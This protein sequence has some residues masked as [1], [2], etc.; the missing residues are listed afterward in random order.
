MLEFT[1]CYLG[2]Y[3]AR[4]RLY[5]VFFILM[6]LM[7]SGCIHHK[8]N[9][10][11]SE[12]PYDSSKSSARKNAQLV[13][14]YL[15]QGYTDFAQEKLQI[16][17]QQAPY[18]P[19]VLDTAGYFYEKTGRIKVANRYYKQAV[20]SAPLSGFAKNNY[21]SFLCRNGYYEASIHYFLEA[22]AMPHTP[23]TR[24]ALDNAKYCKLQIKTKLG[25]HAT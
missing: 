8:Q 21:G 7:L 6:A 11:T 12:Q 20:S 16:A 2:S 19:V 5:R 25:D 9:L 18:D 4:I 24:Q 3:M 13:F 14:N 15:H 23:I 22:A 10:P 17:L 1:Q